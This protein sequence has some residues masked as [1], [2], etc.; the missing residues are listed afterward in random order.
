MPKA[1]KAAAPTAP[2]LF[3]LR[4]PSSSASQ[5]PTAEAFTVKLLERPATYE[6][7]PRCPTL[8]TV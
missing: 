4:F 1:S 5:E 2:T 8:A 7:R 3:K 6:V